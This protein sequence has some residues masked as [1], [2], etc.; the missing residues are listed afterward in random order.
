MTS[1]AN[2]PSKRLLLSGLLLIASTGL[3]SIPQPTLASGSIGAGG[4]GISHFGQAYRQ[5]KKLFFHKI[6][7]SQPHCPIKRH[8]VNAKLAASLV[9]TLE[10]RD[11]LKEP[12]EATE[13]DRLIKLL[14]PGDAAGN[15]ADRPDEQ[16]LVQ[17]YLT[18][19]F[20][21]KKPE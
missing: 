4:G 1:I 8:D 20:G 5:G 2:T 21:L 19:R 18:R 16:D 9:E 7:C 17:Y 15:C 14:C 3:L 12:E 11:E 13:N 10:N 6:A